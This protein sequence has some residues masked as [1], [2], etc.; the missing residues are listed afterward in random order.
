MSD[1]GLENVEL[2]G[3]RKLKMGS[4]EEVKLGDICT[5]I[6]SG[7]TPTGGSN[8][9]KNSGI[10]LIRSQNVL[11]FSFSLDGLAF[12]DESQAEKL[13]N[14]TVEQGDVL[15]NITGDSVARVCI[16]PSS[17]L[18]A[19][20]NQHV[21][22][23]RV[24]ENMA[25][26]QFVFYYAQHIKP[27][28]LSMAS[29]GGT[30]NALTKAMIEQLDIALP[31]LP[32]QKAIAATLSALDDAIELNNQINKKL[33]E[34]AQAIFRSWFVDFEPFKNGEFEESELGLIP[35]G[36]RVGCL[37]D[38]AD[39]RTTV[40][41]RKDIQ[42]GSR[43]V[44][45]EH[46]PRHELTISESG[47]IDEVSSDKLF[48][49]ETQILFGK[50]R[51]Y[52]HKVSIAPWDGYCSTD[53]IVLEPKERDFFAFFA[54]TVFSTEFVRYAVLISHGTKM[55]RAEWKGLKQY[56][57][58]T[59]TNE[60]VVRFNNLIS[61]LIDELIMRKKENEKLKELRDTL[62]PK[63]MSGEIRVPLEN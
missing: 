58:V 49:R 9:Y 21:S 56:R 45:L 34:M 18:P 12:I 63:L 11:D 55:P 5:K 26:T 43:Y 6:G 27:S 25:S 24:A 61:P 51:P 3:N 13:K 50:I 53:A 47:T 31:S 19:R 44:G 23:I 8:A 40:C 36:W 10:S 62:L 54:L 38:I 37:G 42:S 33:E 30:R 1:R 46:I 32:E 4:W 59:P 29:N 57:L 16:V 7:A 28:L 14:V 15:L 48:F 39:S 52:F 60:I 22:I 17:I 35:K 41:R 2:I 20:V